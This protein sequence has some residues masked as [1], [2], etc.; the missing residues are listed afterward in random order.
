M[1]KELTVGQLRNALKNVPDD[2]PV[3]LSSDTGVDQGMGKVIV[4][5]AH[6]CHYEEYN[7]R[8]FSIYANDIIEEDEEY[9]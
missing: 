6:Y 5:S 2:V 7:I 9:E 4:L 8:E 3:V 1:C